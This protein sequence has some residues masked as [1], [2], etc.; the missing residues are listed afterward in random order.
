[1]VE[2]KIVI[3]KQALKDKD[4]IKQHP[5]LKR[6]VE[7]LLELIKVEPFKNPPPYES[8]VG[9]LK[10]LYSRRINRQHRLVYRVLEEEKTI[11]IVSMWTHYEF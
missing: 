10:G 6:T 9:N 3:L 11:M 7:K 8:L 2:Y 1:M 4:K 5:A